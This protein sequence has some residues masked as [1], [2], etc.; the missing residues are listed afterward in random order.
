MFDCFMNLK[1]YREEKKDNK[2]KIFFPTVNQR[3]HV[4]SAKVEISRI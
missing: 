2:D 3:Q 1:R 4:K